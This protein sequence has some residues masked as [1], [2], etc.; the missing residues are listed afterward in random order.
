MHSASGVVVAVRE[1]GRGPT[2]AS[3]GF[4]RLPL[5]VSFF[6]TLVTALG[7]SGRA[8]AS[9]AFEAK[10]IFNQRCTACHTYGKGIKVGPDLKGVTERRARPWLLRFIRSSQTLILARDPLAAGLFQQF[11]QQR[12]PDWIDLSESQVN[13]ILDWISADGPDQKEPDERDAELAQ[14]AD[15]ERARGLFTGSI[16]FASGGAACGNCHSIQDGGQTIGGSLGPDL[17]VAYLKYRD[18]GLT[19]FLRQPCFRRDPEQRAASPTRYLTPDESFVLKA[20]LRRAALPTGSRAVS[21]ASLPPSPPPLPTPALP[22]TKIEVSAGDTT[23]PKITTPATYTTRRH[24]PGR[25]G[26]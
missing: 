5:L 25:G 14:P 16:G 20:Y 4:V 24:K 6:A 17:T 12:M 23:L 9:D 7:S 19:L 10:K 2:A 3:F 8:S 18:R 26:R 15:I 22:P 21:P 13:A 1:A 11:G